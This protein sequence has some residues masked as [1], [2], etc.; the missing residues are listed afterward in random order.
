[1]TRNNLMLSVTHNEAS[2]RARSRPQPKRQSRDAQM[3]CARKT[4]RS[5]RTQFSP[6]SQPEGRAARLR[7][8]ARSARRTKN[9]WNAEFFAGHLGLPRPLTLALSRRRGKEK[10]NEANAAG[11]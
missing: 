7:A 9:P 11:G 3:V 4:N 8:P 1:M 2:A 6:G 5:K 10:Q